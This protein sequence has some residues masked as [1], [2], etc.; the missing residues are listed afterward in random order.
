MRVIY[1]NIDPFAYDQKVYVYDENNNSKEIGKA[2]LE[3]LHQFIA[4]QCA[5]KDI[6]EVTLTGFKQYTEEMAQ[7]ILTYSKAK[8][9]GKT[10]N[11]TVR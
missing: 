11:V 1:C 6:E 2:P 8:Y 10:I 9:S 3:Y 4:N 7:K 5:E